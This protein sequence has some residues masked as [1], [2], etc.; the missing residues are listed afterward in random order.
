MSNEVE[1]QDVLTTEWDY[2][3]VLDACR[4]DIFKNCYKDY[5]EGNLEERWS[6]GATTDEWLQG[7]FNENGL[8]ISYFSGNP[9][10]NSSGVKSLPGSEWDPSKIF[11]EIV[12]VWKTN[13]DPEL[14]TVHPDSMKEAV[15]SRNNIKGKKNYIIHYIQPHAP[16]IT[17]ESS[18][19]ELGA[20]KLAET[21][22]NSIKDRTFRHIVNFLGK[23]ER[24][25]S[26]ET[27]WKIRKTLRMQP[28]T[29]LEQV[30]R[31]HQ[32]GELSEE[33][34]FELYEENLR[35]A[36][37]SIAELVNE[38][39]GKVV[40]TADHGELLGEDGLWGHRNNSTKEKLRKV[41]WLEVKKS[42]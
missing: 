14:R 16:Y 17:Y 4:F 35:I 15:L 42:K 36:L 37:E 25:L 28:V 40:I 33:D 32:K 20:K 21:D 10:V 19:S 18:F 13:W 41:P 34:V 29:P 27:S 31:D 2:L 22:G 1:E 30:W 9:K 6:P 39:D 24:N 8:N 3:I 5:F 38:L 26:K 23:I 11:E 12:D 7:T